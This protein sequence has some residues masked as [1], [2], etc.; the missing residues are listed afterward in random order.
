M[1]APL[2]LQCPG[3]SLWRLL[4]LEHRLQAHG[5]QQLQPPVSS[6]QPCSCATP[7]ELLQACGVFPDQG[8]NPCL[9]HWQA[10]SL[11]LSHQGNLSID[12]QSAVLSTNHTFSRHETIFFKK[13]HYL[14]CELTPIF[15][16]QQSRNS[17]R[18]KISSSFNTAA[19]KST[20]KDGS[21]VLQLFLT[22]AP[23][24]SFFF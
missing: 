5:L 19:F 10:R 4:L 2:Q 6:A 16:I 24:R 15:N 20:V 9:P 7:G 12:F 8:P 18:R 1:G 17:K 14:P 3:F 13:N 11:T 21:S 23:P 22:T